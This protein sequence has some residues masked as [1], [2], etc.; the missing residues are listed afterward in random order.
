VV[1]MDNAA[2]GGEAIQIRIDFNPLA[3]FAPEV[4][5]NSNGKAVVKVSLPDNLTRYRVMVVAVDDSGNQFG[6]GESSITAR[7]PL[8]VR[9]SAP[10]FLNFGDQFEMPVVLQNQT[11]DLIEADVIIQASNL[12]LDGD[13][14]IKVRIPANDRIEVRFPMSAE[15]AGDAKFRIAATSDDYAD[16]AAGEMPVYTPATTE[17]FA[18]YGVRA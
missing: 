3:T 10:R 9:P 14:G 8:M 12:E 18:T 15:M 4:K 2:T 7:L 16:A 13:M 6:S 11:D 17:A 5:T 1:G